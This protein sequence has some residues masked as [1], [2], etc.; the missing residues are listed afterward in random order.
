MNKSYNTL[1]RN[2]TLVS[3]VSFAFYNLVLFILTGFTD[4]SPVYWISYACLTLALLLSTG[5]IFMLRDRKMI[6][7]DWL[8]S[9]PFYKHCFI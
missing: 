8:L 4:H 5:G 1:F 6:A 7:K 2:I 3:I 9:Y